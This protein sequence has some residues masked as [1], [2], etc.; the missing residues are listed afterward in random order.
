M[1]V[2]GRVC[3]CVGVC[4]C[5]CVCKDIL[6]F[7]KTLLSPP[8][9]NI[10]EYKHTPVT[11]LYAAFLQFYK[12]PVHKTFLICLQVTLSRDH[13]RRGGGVVQASAV[14]SFCSLYRTSRVQ[15]RL[16]ISFEFSSADLFLFLCLILIYFFF[17]F[18]VTH[19]SISPTYVLSPLSL[20]R[21]TSSIPD[22]STCTKWHSNMFLPPH[23]LSLLPIPFHEHRG[24]SLIHH[25][26]R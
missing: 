10:S 23:F 25:R 15:P 22:H 17:S 16:N 24:H 9:Q 7:Y 26:H 11:S 8:A 18:S 2:C 5:V 19:I 3:V 21:H 20:L 14:M 1:C 12:T 6:P 13:K 4:V